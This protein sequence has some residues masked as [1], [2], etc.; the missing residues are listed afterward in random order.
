[1]PAT[2]ESH[3]HT[4]P[5]STDHHCSGC[6][7]CECCGDHRKYHIIGPGYAQVVED[8]DDDDVEMLDVERE[9]PPQQRMRDLLRV[10][11]RRHVVP[12]NFAFAAPQQPRRR[13]RRRVVAP[14]NFA[15]RR[16]YSQT[17]IPSKPGQQQQQADEA[18]EDPYEIFVT[19]P[20][21]FGKG[22]ITI[23]VSANETIARLFIKVGQQMNMCVGLFLLIKGGRGIL[24]WADVQNTLGDF[25][26]RPNSTLLLVTAT[27][28][29]R[30]CRH[31]PKFLRNCVLPENLGIP[32]PP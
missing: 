15:P 31:A 8:D 19:T 20:R 29:C 2:L 27:R 21:E 24:S 9:V 11:R 32:P 14:P 26:I 23:D 1:M 30:R 7:S 3:H 4:C 22:T 10:R 18:K 12:P 13:R 16:Q 28:P 25:H 17:G 5:E 6:C